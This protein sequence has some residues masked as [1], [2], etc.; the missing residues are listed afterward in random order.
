M[1]RS[2]I[3]FLLILVL[4]LGAV[5]WFQAHRER[6]F[7]AQNDVALFEN[8][9][10][11]QVVAV[12]IENLERDSQMR[13]VRDPKVGW[14][15]V[16]PVRV[17][18]ES[19]VLDLL[20]KSALAR[21][22]TKV[23]DSESDLKKLGLDPPRFVLDLESDTHVRQRIEIGAVDVDKGRVHVKARG[24]VVR[25]IR[26]I[27]VMLDMAQDE[28][29]SHAAT[30]LE[31]RD[32][33]EVHRRGKLV[34][35][36][37]TEATDMTFDALA[38]NGEWRV[39]SPVQALLD[40]VPM[41]L[42][43]G[44]AAGLRFEA[45]VDTRGAALAEFGLEDP[46]LTFQFSTARG[47][48]CELRFGR[49]EHRAGNP[50]YGM[51]AGDTNVFAVDLGSLYL[52]G[53]KVEELLDFRLHRFPRAQIDAV[54]FSTAARELRLEKGVFGWTVAEARPGSR[55]F[56]TGLPADPRKVEDALAKIERVEITRFLLDSALSP[57]EIHD[58]IHVRAGSAIAAGSFGA[59]Y[60][61]E[62]G[63]RA[64]R[65][66]R[67][68]D[69]IAAIVDP[70]LLDLVRL[71]KESFWG[72]SI[73]ET[74]EVI[75]HSLTISGQGTERVFQRNSKGLWV[76]KGGELEARE[77]RPIL[78][79][80][81]FLRA[82]EHLPEKDRATL[83]DPIHVVLELGPELKRDLLFG[84]VPAGDAK[85]VVVEYEARRSIP[86]RQDLHAALIEILK[87]APR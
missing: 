22:G 28:Y 84:L 44:G 17:R 81:F 66:Q 4:T 46:E 49:H 24:H 36:N 21:R 5:V 58:S 35:E 48:A 80:I 83:A 51:R 72:L 20:V 15:M 78:D 16:D 70:D 63:G 85:R 75:V 59:D 45:Y 9:D 65:F 79:P 29:K 18:A 14:M 86:E 56:E 40:P 47:A 73:C 42:L 50:W 34:L 82:S 6:D 3:A 71:G 38:E 2:T 10:E 7:D 25:V 87:A 54:Q 74:P 27:E 62:T 26:D 77:L 43:I 37:A 76:P 11:H 57:G 12:R 61:P 39:T 68:G 8:L 1:S 55:V 23:P 33:V 64:V 13:F 30:E 19:G 32:V 69:S 41:S 60:V 52:L 31:A 53:T 67:Q